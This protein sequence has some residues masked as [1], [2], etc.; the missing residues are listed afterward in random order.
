MK[1]DL[2]N[3]PTPWLVALLM[4]AV[5]DV[6]YVTNSLGLTILKLCLA[7]MFSVHWEKVFK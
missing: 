2:L 1:I 3:E 6:A 5:Y 7:H 4:L